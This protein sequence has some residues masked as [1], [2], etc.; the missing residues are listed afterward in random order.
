MAHFMYW[1]QNIHPRCPSKGHIPR[2]PRFTQTIEQG[3][4]T[5]KEG[6]L[7]L[8]TGHRQWQLG[9]INT[10]SNRSIITPF[11]QRTVSACTR[12]NRRHTLWSRPNLHESLSVFMT[13]GN[14]ATFCAVT[15][16]ELD[17]LTARDGENCRR[18][19]MVSFYEQWRNLNA[20]RVNWSLFFSSELRCT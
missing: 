4:G 18:I 8:V 9:Y 15:F 20:W 1:V 7:H 19:P 13:V 16:V 11:I 5:S 3:C 2:T 14:T 12:L 10:N 17:W 6:V